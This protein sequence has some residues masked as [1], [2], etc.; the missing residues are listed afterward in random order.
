MW[1]VYVL[2]ASIQDR[3]PSGLPECAEE[4]GCQVISKIDCAGEE[5]TRVEK[6]TSGCILFVFGRTLQGT[7]VCMRVEGLLPKLYVPFDASKDTLDSVRRELHAEVADRMRGLEKLSV[8]L[9]TRTHFYG[10]E[11]DPTTPS[12]REE[13]SYLEVSYPSLFSW[14]AACQIRKVHSWR[15]CVE[16]LKAVEARSTTAHERDT[17]LPWLKR[18]E[19][20]LR[21]PEGGKAGGAGTLPPPGPPP[22]P[23]EELFV[24]PLTRAMQEVGVGAGK[25]CRVASSASSPDVRVSSCDTELVLQEKEVSPLPCQ[26]IPPLVVSYYDIETMGLDPT[27]HEVIQVSFVVHRMGRPIE[28][29]EKHVVVWGTVSP[30]ADDTQV[31][32]VETEEALLGKFRSLLVEKDPDVLVVYNGFFDSNFLHERAKVHYLPLHMGRFPMEASRFREQSL[33]SSGMGDNVLR[34]FDLSGRINLDWYIKL[35]RDLTSE[36]SYKLQHFAHKFC[37]DSKEEGVHYSEIATLHRQGPDGRA[38]LARYCVKDS[39]LLLQLDEARQM[40]LEIFQ[41]ASVFGIVPEWVYFRGQ[42]V[43]YISQLLSKSR[44]VEPTVLLLNRPPPEENMATGFQ[45][46]TVND[47]TR[48][49]H[50]L[51]ACLDWMSLYP[52]LML[53]HNLCPST[54]LRP[55][56]I[57]PLQALPP[58][59]V[60]HQVGD[61]VTHHFVTAVERRGVLPFIIDELLSNRK[62]AKREMK[63]HSQRAKELAEGDP[64]QA[65]RCKLLAKVCDGRQLALKVATNSIYGANGAVETGKL[66]CLA[67]SASTTYQGRQ[68]MVLKKE[69]LPK[70][71]PDIEIIYGDTD[72]IM[73]KFGRARTVQEAGDLGAEAATKVTEHFALLGYPQLV[74]EFE[75]LYDPYLL[76]NK[77]RYVAIEFEPDAS[78]AMIEKGIKA[79]GLETER[80]DTLPFLKT[81]MKDNYHCLLKLVD[82]QKALE[83]TQAHLDRLVAGQVPME[84]LTLCRFLSSKVSG[85][86]TVPW[87]RVNMLRA[88]R[89]AGSEANVNDQVPYVV[90][91]GYKDTKVSDLAE[92]PEYARAQGLKLNLKWYFEKA[93]KP[94]LERLFE[95]IHDLDATPLFAKVGQTLEAQRLGV[96]PFTQTSRSSPSSS[97][98]SP[99]S[100]VLVKRVRIP[101]PPRRPPPKGGAARGKAVKR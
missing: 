63:Q 24:D 83:R 10:Y 37:G 90:V 6:V 88:Q 50:R 40:T 3:Y 22:R 95:V 64:A 60:A 34:Y 26:D 79:K 67:V 43:R 25:W 73:A 100:S 27:R 76:E 74:L 33:S 1:D 15:E 89:Q 18:Q 58:N 44:T 38:K 45:G 70:L 55:G 68:A 46:A 19:E 2:S 99:A 21:P 57:D 53:A 23:A 29:A 101:E 52:N 82:P 66:A 85:K 65:A 72:S 81:V 51:V 87:A 9:V 69:L 28:E 80:R 11:P 30:L 31:H 39:Y 4:G 91:G 12:G 97:A 7:S 20:T 49:F 94:A 32:E 92:D 5:G 84:E 98:S 41:F 56:T 36:P 16:K 71:Y 62:A 8:S 14:R 54:L 93:I 75:S 13:H 78:N 48:G 86:D 47:P 35:K 42:Q 61:G 17:L 59:V 96:V 77:K